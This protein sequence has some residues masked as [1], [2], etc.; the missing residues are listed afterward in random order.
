MMSFGTHW[1]TLL[2][3]WESN[4][5][6]CRFHLI[7]KGLHMNKAMIYGV[8]IALSSSI[9]LAA[10]KVTSVPVSFAQGL[11]ARGSTALSR[12]MTALTL[13]ACW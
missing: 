8:A 7:F 10:D 12:V 5:S 6:A 2:V 1:V 13:H 4:E 9:C 3:C 11:A